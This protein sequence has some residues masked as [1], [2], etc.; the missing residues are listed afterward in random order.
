MTDCNERYLNSSHWLKMLASLLLL[1]LPLQSFAQEDRELRVGLAECPPFVIKENGTHSGLAVYLWEQVADELGL[2]Y[3]Y[4]EY[5]L[6]SLLEVIHNADESQMPDVGISCTSVTA[7]REQWID[8]SHSFDETYTAIAVRQTTIWTGI[9]RF[10][11]DPRVLNAIFIVL[12]VAALIGLVFY[13]LEHR[14][15]KKLFSSDSTAGRGI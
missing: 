8:F 14:I 6:G 13:L 12:G 7:E 9:K 1:F 11:S 5:A 10:F 4:S 2:Q 3:S 15:N